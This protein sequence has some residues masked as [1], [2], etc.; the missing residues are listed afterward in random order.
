VLVE[1]EVLELDVVLV[2]V[3]V[4][5][6][7]MSSVDAGL[8]QGLQMDELPVGGPQSFPLLFSSCRN[9]PWSDPCRPCTSPRPFR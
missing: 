9:S 8:D 2:V 5:H 7:E 3:V 1:V 6:Q 4:R